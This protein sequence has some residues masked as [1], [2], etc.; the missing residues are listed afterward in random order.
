MHAAPPSRPAPPPAAPAGPLSFAD[1]LNA[2]KKELELPAGMP[3][4][5]AISAA[6]KAMG[7]AP[8]GALP[9]QVDSLYEVIC[10]GS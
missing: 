4:A 3:M 2:I 6:N 5:G 10:G 7:M 8:Q 1:K 9:A